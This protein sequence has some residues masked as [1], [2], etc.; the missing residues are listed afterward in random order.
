METRPIRNV[1]SWTSVFAS[2]G[3]ISS[4]FSGC[5]LPSIGSSLFEEFEQTWA[6]GEQTLEVAVGETFTDYYESF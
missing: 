5:K 1:F 2:F 6:V 4:T 3:R